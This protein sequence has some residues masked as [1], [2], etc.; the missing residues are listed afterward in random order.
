[1]QSVS[2]SRTSPESVANLANIPME[3]WC[4]V[5]KYLDLPKHT[6]S[7]EGIIVYFFEIVFTSSSLRLVR[8]ITISEYSVQLLHDTALPEVLNGFYSYMLIILYLQ[9]ATLYDTCPNPTFSL[10]VLCLE[11]CTDINI[12]FLRWLSPALA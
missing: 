7:G 12:G 5:L 3:V 6:P 1:M 8:T 11:D 10:K 4:H 9:G 2:P